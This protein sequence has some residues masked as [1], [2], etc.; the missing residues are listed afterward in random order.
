M[1][2]STNKDTRKDININISSFTHQIELQCRKNYFKIFSPQ[3]AGG[4]G[5]NRKGTTKASPKIEKICV[6]YIDRMFALPAIKCK[7]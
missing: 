3:E 5:Y 6:L 1:N 2:I 7:W 4:F